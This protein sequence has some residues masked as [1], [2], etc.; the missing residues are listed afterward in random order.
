M[1]SSKATMP[2]KLTKMTRMTEPKK[3]TITQDEFDALFDS[4]L[5]LDY[6]ESHGVDNWDWYG[7]AMKDYRKAKEQLAEEKK[8][9]LNAG[10]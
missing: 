8:G 6:L 2:R 4:S 5:Q 3:I 10:G 9:I 7:D 1:K